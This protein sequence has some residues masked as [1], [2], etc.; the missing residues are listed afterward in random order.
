MMIIIER[1]KKLLEHTTNNR[2]SLILSAFEYI[3]GADINWLVMHS[4][5]TMNNREYN[6]YYFD[7]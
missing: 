2:T 3:Y 4:V 6:N 5:I 7:S 1:I